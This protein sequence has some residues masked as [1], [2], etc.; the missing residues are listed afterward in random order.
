MPLLLRVGIYKVVNLDT[1]KPIMENQG[2]G[3]PIRHR[4]KRKTLERSWL[5]TDEGM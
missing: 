3:R 4:C 2:G 1:E 5:T